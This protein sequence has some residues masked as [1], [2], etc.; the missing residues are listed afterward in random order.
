MEGGDEGLL[1]GG[2]GVEAVLDAA[3]EVTD[4]GELVGEVLPHLLDR[5]LAVA[6]AGHGGVVGLMDAGGGGGGHG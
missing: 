3:A 6:C 2:V 5:V 1:V 4:G